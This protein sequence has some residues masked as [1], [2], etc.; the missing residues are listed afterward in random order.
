MPKKRTRPSTKRTK[1]ATAKRAA[2]RKAPPAKKR[3]QRRA[4]T[5][6]ADPAIGTIGWVDL[7]APDAAALRDFYADVVGWRSEAFKMEGYS[8]FVMSTPHGGKAMT[9]ICHARGANADLPTQWLIYVVVAD[10]DA[11]LAAVSR[12]G[13]TLLSGPREQMGGRFAV[14]RDPAGA[15]LAIWQQ[16]PT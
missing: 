2:P 11:S 7:T 5:L 6:R 15:V 3:A 13:G 1:P 4:T 8:D 10:L 14:I 9:G 16:P 12:L